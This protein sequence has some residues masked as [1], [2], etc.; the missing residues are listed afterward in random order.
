MDENI[1]MNANEII[2]KLN[3]KSKNSFRKNYLNPAINIGLIN[4]TIPDK[5]NSKNQ[6]YYK[7]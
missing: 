2:E 7:K 5:P 4:L 1:P 6:S 3:L